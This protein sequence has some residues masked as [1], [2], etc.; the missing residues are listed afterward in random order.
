MSVLK[1]ISEAVI[2]GE[3]EKAS[4]LTKEALKHGVDPVS[5]FN[6][7]LSKGIGIVGERFGKGELFLFDL[8][9]GAEAMKAC[10]IDLEPE[11][12]RQKKQIDTLGRFL[13]GTVA[14]DIHDIG[15]NI[16]SV[17]L[18]VAGFE[19]TDLGTDVKSERFVEKAHEVKADILGLSALMTPTLPEQ[20]K[21]IDSLAKSASRDRV[22]V[23]VGG[24]VATE[25]W[26]REIGADSYAGDAVTGVAQAKELMA[27]RGLV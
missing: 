15:K 20:K 21:V 17:M 4:Q 12:T 5:I 16:V 11:M 3:K 27:T 23:M 1:E 22:K 19:V 14:G 25:R 10:M 2:E 9:R 18:R 8:M 7:G 13:I 24:A 26:A 6:D